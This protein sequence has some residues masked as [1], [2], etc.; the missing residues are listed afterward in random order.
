MHLPFGIPELTSSWDRVRENCDCAGSDGVT[1]GQFGRNAERWIRELLERVEMDRY[2]PFP[3]LTIVVA[4][5]PTGNAT[6]TLLVSHGRRPHS[7]D[8]SG[9]APEHGMG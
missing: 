2:R 3:L 7:A 6:R 5:K 9:P 8:S 4:K 1:I